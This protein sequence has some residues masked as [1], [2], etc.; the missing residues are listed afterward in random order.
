MATTPPRDFF[1]ALDRLYSQAATDEDRKEVIYAAGRAS[2]F[3][4]DPAPLLLRAGKEGDSE[5][6]LIA[7]N[8]L[9]SFHAGWVEVQFLYINALRSAST[10]RPERLGLIE[11]APEV[12]DIEAP[13]EQCLVEII[14]N[15]ARWPRRYRAAAAASLAKLL[16]IS[17]S[18]G[19]R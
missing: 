14:Q 9:R 7:L 6:G 11:Q 4:S 19:S 15:H 5:L 1:P 10:P 2:L 3:L 8:Q 17:N 12:A 18:P 13:Y 16:Q